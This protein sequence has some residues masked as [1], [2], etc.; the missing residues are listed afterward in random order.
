MTYIH[1]APTARNAWGVY[2]RTVEI[3]K[4]IIND[5]NARVVRTDAHRLRDAERRAIQVFIE[6]RG[7]SETVTQN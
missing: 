4:V 7:A 6:Q 5:H 3:A 1:F 2:R